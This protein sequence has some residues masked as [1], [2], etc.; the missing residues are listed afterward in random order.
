MYRNQEQLKVFAV[1]KIR[2]QGVVDL[3]DILN[4][5]TTNFLRL[6][7]IPWMAIVKVSRNC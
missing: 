5:K 6:I 7:I 4:T 1:N 3:V 2:T